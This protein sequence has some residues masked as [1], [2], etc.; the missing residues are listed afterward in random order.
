MRNSQNLLGDARVYS[1][2]TATRGKAQGGNRLNYVVLDIETA[3]DRAGD[4]AKLWP[5]SKKKPGIHAIISQV[6]C[7]GLSVNGA[8]PEAI[9]RA[10]FAT[11]KDMMI[12]LAERLKELKAPYALPSGASVLIPHVVD[13]TI[14]GFNIKSFDLPI[15]QLRAAKYGVKIELPAP[16]SSRCVDLFERIGGKWQTD[17]S[18]CSLSELAWFLYGTPKSSSGA[19]VAVWWAKGDYQAIREHCLADVE[20]TN[21]IYQDYTGVLW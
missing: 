8:K 19:E 17:T 12:N 14:I 7:I 6:V 5:K 20:L 13:P 10:D 9:D 21:K 3:P 18:A 4:Y 1:E 2:K 16:K 15:L 11:E